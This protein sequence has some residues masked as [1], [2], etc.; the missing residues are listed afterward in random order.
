MPKSDDS[1]T[2]V[3]FTEWQRRLVAAMAAALFTVGSAACA[4]ETEDPLEQPVEQPAEDDADNMA[5]PE[6]ED[7]SDLEDAG[8]R[9]SSE[10]ESSI[11]EDDIQPDEDEE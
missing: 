1:E 3:A 4:P 9:E 6:S 11:S 8:D 5:D 2:T 7:Q 10:E